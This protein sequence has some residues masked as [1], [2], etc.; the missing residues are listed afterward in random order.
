LNFKLHRT[1]DQLEQYALGRLADT[2]VNELE[3]HLMVCE[4]CRERLDAIEH[5]SRAMREALT[6][7]PVPVRLPSRDWFAWLRRPAFSM[8]LVLAALIIVMSIFSG[9]KTKLPPVSTLQLT[10][11]RGEMPAVKPAREIDLT[12]RDAPREAGPFRIEVV[13]S[14]GLKVWNSLADSDA[15]GVQVHVQQQLTQGDYFVR[16]YTADGRM[17]HEYGFHIRT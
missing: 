7:E 2:E 13:D 14:T 4:A 3:D 17:L 8:A 12:L 6:N 16:L 11:N 10:A 9:G 1:E 15:Q 5:F